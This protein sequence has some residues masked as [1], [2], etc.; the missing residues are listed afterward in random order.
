MLL[1]VMKA[2]FALD[3]ESETPVLADAQ[4]P[5]V[6]SDEFFGEP[7][8]SAPKYESEFAL[9]K[10]FCD[11]LL[12]ATAYAPGGRP[13]R[14][15][16][17]EVRV[18]SW[19]KGFE[20][21]GD[22]FWYVNNGSI[23][24]TE[25][26]PFVSMSITYERAFGGFDDRHEDANRHE[27]F[28]ANSV[29][30]GFSAL[31]DAQSLAGRPLPNTQEFSNPIT[32]PDGDYKP[33]SFGPVGRHWEPRR[34]YAGTYDQKWLD[35]EFPFLPAD[36]DSQYFQSAPADQQLPLPVGAQRVVLKNLT[37]EG[38]FTFQLPGFEACVHILPRDGERETL[39]A[40]ADS[41]LI[42]PDMKRVMMTWRVTRPLR[43]NVFELAHVI[44]GRM[45]SL[46]DIDAGQADFV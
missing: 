46:P 25:P 16:P 8:L 24:A 33:M 4:T 39:S 14:K 40:F 23:V 13:V 17:V 31:L 12:N 26:Q 44:V 32:R 38:A 28:H 21:V 43:K 1:V 9:H 37:P 35:E 10:P 2:T 3:F 45:N 5:I 27:A 36:F 7:G 18:G 6:M 34:H 41:I 42:E 20:V 19:V 15:V 29:G 11:V 22:R 30:R